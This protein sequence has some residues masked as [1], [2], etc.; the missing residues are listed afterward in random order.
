[1]SMG[2]SVRSFK[3]LRV[4]QTAMDAAEDTYRLTA[5]FPKHETYG[6]CS[7]MQRAAVSVP[8]NIAEGHARVSTKDY[9]HHLSIA[10]GSLAELETQ[11]IL[12]QRLK[13]CPTNQPTGFEQRIQ[14]VGKMLGGLQRS[15]T[16][17][18]ESEAQLAQRQRRTPRS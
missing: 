4:W 3:Q 10:A 1:M 17:K 11:F 15:L 14:D 18:L 8:S 7:Q 5:K 9:L 6:L 12:S 2:N 16:A 13:Y